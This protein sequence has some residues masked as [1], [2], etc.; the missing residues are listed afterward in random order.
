MSIDL[1]VADHVARV[2]INRPERLNAIDEAHQDELL[3]TWEAIEADHSVRVVVLTGAGD[4]SFCAGD[5]MRAEGATD[6]DYWLRPRRDGFGHLPLRD[7]LDVP[8]LARVNGYALGGGLELVVGCDLAVASEDSVLG[9][10]EP[11]LGRL[12]LDGGIVSLARQLPAKWAMEVLLTGKRFSATEALALGLLN[13][14]VP[15]AELDAA[16]DRWLEEL[17]ACAPL[18]LR[19]IKQI[20]RRTPH[21]TASDARM[22]NLPALV[23]VLTSS[24]CDEGIRAFSE[25]RAPRWEGR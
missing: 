8:V 20:V 22:A 23:E 3:R 18:S 24:D 14:V 5:D 13:E 2:T 1:V 25:K 12:P 16:V 6:L 17:L 4:R 7:S 9:F 10:V 11:R 19:A 15:A 21:M